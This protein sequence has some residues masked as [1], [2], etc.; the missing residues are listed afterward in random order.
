MEMM[1]KNDQAVAQPNKARNQLNKQRKTQLS[2]NERNYSKKGQS[3]S[4]LHTWQEAI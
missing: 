1:G 3:Q 2:T 4:A